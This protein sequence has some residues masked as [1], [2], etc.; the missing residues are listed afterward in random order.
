MCCLRGLYVRR[1]LKQQG[2]VCAVLRLYVRRPPKQQGVVCAVLGGYMSEDPQNNKVLYVL[3]KGAT[4]QETPKMYCYWLFLLSFMQ[5]IFNQVFFILCAFKF[6]AKY[7]YKHIFLEI[8]LALS[9]SLKTCTSLS[10]TEVSSQRSIWK[11]FYLVCS[12][13]MLLSVIWMEGNWLHT[14]FIIS[15][16]PPCEPNYL[17]PWGHLFKPP[18]LGNACNI[19]KFG[20][21]LTEL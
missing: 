7:L 3:S 19:E 9:L 11:D 18:T 4:C 20:T 2:V 21:L 14:V 12:L 15:W 6:Y 1:P 10:A 16:R 5:V 13:I 17:Q 8:H